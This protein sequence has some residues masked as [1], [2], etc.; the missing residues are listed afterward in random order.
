MVQ[1]SF[2]RHD[3]SIS[4]TTLDHERDHTTLSSSVPYSIFH[5]ST[6]NFYC[7]DI[8]AVRVYV[9]SAHSIF[10]K[11]G[12]RKLEYGTVYK[13][14]RAPDLSLSLCKFQFLDIFIVFSGRSY[15][16]LTQRLWRAVQVKQISIGMKNSYRLHGV[17]VASNKT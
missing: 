3:C 7:E 9:W 17:S 14:R 15:Q 5:I 10:C 11:I 2:L 13:K 8:R 1:I 12:N 6:S 16:L 4:F